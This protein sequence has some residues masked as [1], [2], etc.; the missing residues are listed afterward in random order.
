MNSCFHLAFPVTDLAIARQFYVE[1]L[2]C[3]A[4]RQSSSALIL[5]LGGHQIVA[6]LTREPLPPQ[7]GIYPRHF[8]LIFEQESDWE[9]LCERA[10]QQNLTFYHPPRQRFGGTALEHRTFFLVDPFQNLLE[11]KYYRHPEAIFG[12]TE[13]ALVG[14]AM[15]RSNS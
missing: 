1:G 7:Q 12:A 3:S 5:N 9:A 10:K 2:G 11:F 14:D 4:G 15:I 6:H 8:G 13:Q